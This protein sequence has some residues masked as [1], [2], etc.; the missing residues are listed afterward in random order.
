[1]DTYVCGK[2]GF[3]AFGSAP[4]VCPVCAA[5]KEAFELDNTAIKRPADA[6]NLSE[7]EKKA[8]STD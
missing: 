6:K 1:M 2:C 4:D 3:I 7:L 5:K 8:Y